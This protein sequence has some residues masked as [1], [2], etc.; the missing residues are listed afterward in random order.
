MHILF[1][2][3]AV[4]MNVPK[5]YPWSRFHVARPQ[6]FYGDIALIV[7]HCFYRFLSKRLASYALIQDDSDELM[8][9]MGV[10]GTANRLRTVS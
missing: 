1:Q 6:G 7:D 5:C 9:T 3:Q 8:L 4:W 2:F 10:P